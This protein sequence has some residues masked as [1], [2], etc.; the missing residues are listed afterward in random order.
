VYT[1]SRKAVCGIRRI[2]EDRRVS[3]GLTQM[4]NKLWDAGRR[5]HALVSQVLPSRPNR[6]LRTSWS[7]AYYF[8]K[9]KAMTYKPTIGLEIHTEL[10]T[11][12]KM[13]CDSLNDPDEKRPNTNVC[14]VCLGHPGTLPT[15]NVQAV[16]HVLR[17]GFALGAKIPE[18]SKFDRKNY[19]YP[20]LPKGY[21]ISQYDEPLC[22]GGTLALSILPQADN[23][24]LPKKSIRIRRIHLEED[25]GKLVHPEAADYS[26]VDFN[27]AGVPLMELVTE[28]DIVSGREAR[29]FAE[30]LQL[31]FRYLGVSDAD[32]EKGQMRIEAN[33]SVSKRKDLGTKV[34]VKNLNSFRSV[35]EAIDYEIKRQTEVLEEGSEIT[36]E[37]RGWNEAKKETL[38]QRLKEEAQDY[39]YFPEPDL[40]PLYLGVEPQPGGIF[41]DL[42]AI[43]K[44]LSEFPWQRRNRF[45]AEYGLSEK[46]VEFLVR[47]NDYA[48]F[49]EEAV[50]EFSLEDRGH[51][52][53]EQSDQLA[54]LVYNYLSSDL[55]GLLMEKGAELSEIKIKPEHLAHLVFFIHQDKISSRAAK[56]V[57]LKMLETGQDPEHIIREEGLFQIADNGE[58]EGIVKKVLDREMQAVK[59]YKAGKQTALQFLAGRVMAETRGRANPKTVQEMISRLLAGN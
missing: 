18:R 7:G 44:S 9:L 19:F 29:A 22:R 11:R 5:V 51:D 28:P 37:T 14:P 53:K 13:F 33:I 45:M 6:Q 4:L 31:L 48:T 54:K 52:V 50:S 39:R 36:Q 16:E 40:P 49:F 35:E 2:D 41:I 12:T 59:D 46:D 34:E 30:E 3:W 17:V 8:S 57:L 21:Q 47:E 42:G 1:G 20:D 25:T 55:K 58:L 27:R 23:Y 24:Q 15:I 38:S 32:M 10:K 43:Q 56:N 26:L